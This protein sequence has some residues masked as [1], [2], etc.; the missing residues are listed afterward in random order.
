MNRRRMKPHVVPS[1]PPSAATAEVGPHAERGS[2]LVEILIALGI[3]AVVLT[4]FVSI[5]QLGVFSVGDIQERTTA[6]TLARSQIE[7]IKSAPW[8][9]PYPTLAAPTGYSV[10][11]S[12]GAGPMPTIQV[13]SV[14]IQHN[15][16]DVLTTQA[17]KGQR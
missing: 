3:M 11:T 4:V 15:G 2:T 8:P 5:L 6:M 13:I 1:P 7:T 16:R 14:R 12:V 17:Y 9:G 10:T